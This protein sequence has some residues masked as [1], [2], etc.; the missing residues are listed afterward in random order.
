MAASL[1]VAIS[2]DDQLRRSRGTLSLL[3]RSSART[4]SAAAEIDGLD[5]TNEPLAR[6]FAELRTGPPGLTAAE[7][8]TRLARRTRGERAP[9]TAALTCQG[10]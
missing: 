7:V 2:P 10:M 3:E 6:V 5:V 4:R 1:P 8:R 9:L